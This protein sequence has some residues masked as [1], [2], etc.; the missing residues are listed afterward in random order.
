M[1]DI[2]LGDYFKILFLRPLSVHPPLQKIKD[3]NEIKTS[4]TSHKTTQLI[5]SDN[6]C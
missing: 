4:D 2:I 1:N 6:V 3:L 5:K